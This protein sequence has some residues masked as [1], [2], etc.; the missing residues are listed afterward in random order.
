MDDERRAFSDGYLTV[1]KSGN[2]RVY[3]YSDKASV[4]G[5][6]W[7]NPAV[8]NSRGL[9]VNEYD[10]VVARPWKK[11]FN[12][13]QP[14]AGKLDFQAPVEVTDKADG[15]LIVLALHGSTPSGLVASTR[16]SLESDQAKHA[17]YLLDTPGTLWDGYSPGDIMRCSDI[18]P[19]FEVIYP[20]NRIVLNYEDFDNLVLLGGVRI[21]TGEYLSPSEVSAYLSWK[22]CVTKTMEY[23]TLQEALEAKPR[24]NAEGLVVRF[25]DENKLVKIKQED[26]VLAH[27]AIF[28]MNEL[29]IWEYM[30]KGI[31]VSEILEP[32]PDEVHKWVVDSYAFFESVVDENF[33]RHLSEYDCLQFELGENYTRKDFAIAASS[34]KEFITSVFFHIEDNNYDKAWYTIL[35]TLRPTGGGGRPTLEQKI[36]ES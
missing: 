9:I 14:Q 4:D 27:R 26:Y 25:L 35:K 33:L 16:G 6:S 30:M 12:H 22:G 17:Q 15:S 8:L 1:R 19:L 29:T 36:D 32:L 11:F 23:K 21:S 5:E 3:N 34:K 10:E 24:P 20:D 18:T 7:D 31:P 13:N 28:G 2:L